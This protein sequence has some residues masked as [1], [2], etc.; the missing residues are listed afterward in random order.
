MLITAAESIGRTDLTSAIESAYSAA[1]SSGTSPS[2]EAAA[3]LRCYRLVENEVALDHLPLRAQ[4]TLL[5]VDGYVQFSDFSHS[6]VDVI[7]VRDAQGSKTEFEV[8]ASRLYVGTGSGSVT[9]DYTYVPEQPKI[10]DETAFSDKVSAR[11]PSASPMNTCS[12]RDG[13]PRRRCGKRSTAMRWP[14]RGSRAENCACG[15]GGGYDA[16]A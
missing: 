7:E 15:H 16:L 12:P 1:V 5:P 8:L 4:D 13:T 6:P 10:S 9:I 2:G 11:L 14:R 3:L